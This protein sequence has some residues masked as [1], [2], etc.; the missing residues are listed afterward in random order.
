MEQLPERRRLKRLAGKMK[1]FRDKLYVALQTIGTAG[2]QETL[3]RSVFPDETPEL[4]VP[5]V[6]KVVVVARRLLKK[7]RAD[8]DRVEEPASN[9]DVTTIGELIDGA[10]RAVRDHWHSQ[11]RKKLAPYEKLG[12]VARKLDLPGA[13]ELADVMDRLRKAEAQPPGSEK[14]AADVRQDLADLQKAVQ[15]LGFDDE[16]VRKFLI[17]ASVGAARLQVLFEKESIKKFIE[18]HKLWAL[19]RVSTN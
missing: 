7:L 17:D 5:R 10:S 2:M 4:C 19:F 16:A 1:Q 9:T 3:V 6:K 14:R 18:D 8:M 11:L 12:A 13:Q 15:R